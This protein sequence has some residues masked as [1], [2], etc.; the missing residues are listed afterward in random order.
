VLI[1]SR[2][3]GRRLRH[4]GDDDDGGNTVGSVAFRRSAFRVV[5]TELSWVQ[6]FLM[7]ILECR[8]IETVMISGRRLSLEQR[9]GG[10]F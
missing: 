3:E 4:R 6:L 8:H 5:Q 9:Y 1:T 10:E 7:M 2:W